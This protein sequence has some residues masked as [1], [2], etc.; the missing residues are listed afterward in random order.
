MSRLPESSN[1][2]A[3]T[4]LGCLFTPVLLFIMLLPVDVNGYSFKNQLIDRTSKKFHHWNSRKKKITGFTTLEYSFNQETGELLEISRNLDKNSEVFTEKT[5]WFH[6]KS[7]ELIKY[8]EEDYRTDLRTLN[9]YNKDRI[10]TQV[11]E[12]DKKREFKI[13]ITPELVPFE[14]LS[15]YLQSQINKLNEKKTIRF[16]MYLPVVAVELTNKGLPLSLSQLSMKA[17]VKKKKTRDTLWGKREVVT[18]RVEP[19]SFF[20]RTLLG[21]KKSKFDFYF[22]NQQPYILV[23]FKEGDTHSKMIEAK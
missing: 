9:T 11:W 12:N 13:K 19:T 8:Q 15:F 22:I 21:E 2:I 6:E 5:L 7:G 18:V 3:R 10:L 16:T 4:T 20:V 17:F 14:V 23:Q 1:S